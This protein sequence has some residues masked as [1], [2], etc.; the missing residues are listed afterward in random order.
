MQSTID[1]D[2][3]SVIRCSQMNSDINWGMDLEMGRNE[4][5]IAE[6]EWGGVQKRMEQIEK[7]IPGDA[8]SFASPKDE[9]ES[10]RIPDRYNDTDS[11]AMSEDA[12]TMK[13]GDGEPISD[14]DLENIA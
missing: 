8:A 3:E 7:R 4:M 14:E 12:G 13:I 6:K 9:T 11:E 10:E 2:S 5:Q 1:Y